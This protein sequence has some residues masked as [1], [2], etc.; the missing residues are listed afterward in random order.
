MVSGLFADRNM[1]W[2]FYRLEMI[3]RSPMKH[4]YHLLMV[5]FCIISAYAQQSSLKHIGLMPFRGEGYSE[6]QFKAITAKFQDEIFKIN[7]FQLMEQEKMQS[8]LKEQGLNESGC[9][10]MSCY[11]EAGKAVG[12]E[13]MLM[14]TLTRVGKI[15]SITSKIVDVATGKIVKSTVFDTEDPYEK[16]ISGHLAPLA[17]KRA[18]EASVGNSVY[19]FDPSQKREPIAVLEV[20][21]NGIEKSETKGLSDRLRAELFNTGC[22]DVMERE[23]MN[24]ILKEQGFQ[25]S[26]MCDEASCL[27]QVGQLVGV[28]YMVGSSVTRIGNLYSVSA[29]II[30][31]SSGKIVRTATADVTGDLEKV[32]K[33]TMQDIARSIS[34]L[35]VY[36]RANIPAYACLGTAAVLAGVGG[37]FTKTGNDAH[38]QYMAEEYNL[39]ALKKYKDDATMKYNVSY[40]F[41]GGAVAAI[42][43]S[44]YLFLAKRARLKVQN[45]AKVPERDGMKVEVR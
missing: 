23:Q 32:L 9:T 11:V 17:D 3:T 36:S 31:V 1:D 7:K 34:G 37:Y 16:I 30:D 25:Q 40:G 14:G 19:T 39:D 12:V 15:T 26:G 35:K 43:V 42:G 41:Y 33:E 44:A 18:G 24:D 10:Q 2:I 21:G 45:V 28:K 6:E 4:H 8:I 22:Y 29:R 27:V 13:Q 20:S 5:L 38:A